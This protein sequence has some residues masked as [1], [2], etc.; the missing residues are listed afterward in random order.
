PVRI[1]RLGAVVGAAGLAELLWGLRSLGRNLTPGVEPLPAGELVR[2]GA[3]A[4]VRHPIY[5][6]LILVLS[7]YALVW[8]NWRLAL[9]AGWGA[10]LFF[11]GKA[12]AEERHLEERFTGYTKYCRQVPRL[13]PWGRPGL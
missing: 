11:E 2:T 13:L 7:G 9:I 4:R 12:K 1:R 5:L 10:L 6:G 8:S 3:Y